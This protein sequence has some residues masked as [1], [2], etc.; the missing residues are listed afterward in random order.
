MRQ[1]EVKQNVMKCF[2][3][4]CE[5]TKCRVEYPEDEVKNASD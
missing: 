3:K 4:M 5:G 1:L 2:K